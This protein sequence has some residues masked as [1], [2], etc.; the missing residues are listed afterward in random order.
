MPAT[1]EPDILSLLPPGRMGFTPAEPLSEDEFFDLCQRV[2]PLRLERDA[3]G[4]IVVMSPA[5]SYSSN[6]SGEIFGQL[7]KCTRSEEKGAA[8][9]SSGEFPLPNGATRAP[10][11]AWV[12]SE[13]LEDLSAETKEKFL[14]LGPE[15]AVEVRSENDRR[16]DLE[17]KMREYV[18]NGTRLS[19]LIDP[20]TETVT[21]Y[22]K[23]G[24]SE[25][26][27]RPER[28]EANAVV[29]GFTLPLA[30]IW[31]PLGESDA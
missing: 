20:Q 1:A 3:K 28:V 15:F 6:R 31:E 22:R 18:E 24:S 23:D 16:E 4:T 29:D 21:M 13:R 12:S 14:P 26:L 11:A 17:A 7:R 5:G 25:T 10:D 2:D 19:W 30:R 8:F 27:N 9:D